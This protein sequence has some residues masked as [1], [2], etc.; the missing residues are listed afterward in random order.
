[1][2]CP[3]ESNIDMWHSRLIFAES[4][5]SRSV[6]IGSMKM[7]RSEVAPYSTVYIVRVYE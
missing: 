3:H 6:V 5:V 7:P 1:M 2:V 4:G